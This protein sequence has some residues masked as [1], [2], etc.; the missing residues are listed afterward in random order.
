MKKVLSLLLVLALAISL[1]AGCGKKEEATGTAEVTKEEVNDVVSEDSKEVV[2]EETIS[3]SITVLTN[4]TDIVDSVFKEQ[5]LPKFNEVYP[6]IKVE[7]EAIAD[8]VGTVKIRMNTAEYGDV[9]LLPDDLPLEDNQFYFEPLGSVDEL[10]QKYLFVDEKAYD[11][12]VYGIPVVVN[13]QGVVY[14]KKVFEAAGVT[15][16]PTSTEEFLAALQMVKDNTDAIPYYTNYASG[17]PL[18][19]WENHRTSVA[20]DPNYVNEMPHL[21]PFVEGQPHYTLYK[22]MYDLVANGLVEDDP[23]TADWELSKQLIGTGQVASMVLGSW[24]VVQMQEAAVANGA[25]AQDIGYMPFPYTNADGN[26]Y[27]NSGG[28]Y[29]IGINVNSEEKEAAKAWLDWFINDSGFAADQGGISPVKGE[30]FPD[31]LKDF[32]AMDVKLIANAPAISG[33]EGL[34][35]EVD[36][37]AEIGLWSDDWKKRIVEGALGY[38]GESYEDIMADL[39]AKWDAAREVVGVN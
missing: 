19:Q 25:S 31:T 20:G 4:R 8:Y 13:A 22:L 16:I 28:D 7:F 12:V 15:S 27:A 36:A 29:K 30:A 39:A 6:D 18:T 10:S 26:I 21:N 32:E 2:K 38:T 9:L 3:G 11:G 5:Y 14:N 17:W 35:D 1:F 34:L 37:E 33:E 24:A 23:V